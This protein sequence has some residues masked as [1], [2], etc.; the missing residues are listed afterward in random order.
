MTGLLWRWVDKR[1]A[2]SLPPLQHR[3]TLGD[4]MED[5]ARRT[6]SHGLLLAAWWLVRECRDVSRVYR[7]GQYPDSSRRFRMPS[8]QLPELRLAAR[9]LRRQPGASAASIVTLATAFAAALA[10]W[11]L[12]DSVLLTPVQATNP[13]RLLVVRERYP[14]RDG[15][16]GALS[17]HMLFS[18]LEPLRASTVLDFVA[19]IGRNPL[20]IGDPARPV[21]KDVAFVTAN[22]FDT[23]GVRIIHGRGFSTEDDKAGAPVLAV[24]TH[25]YWQTEFQADPSVLGKTIRTGNQTATIVGVAP[26]GFR[27][28]NVVD[29]P[30]LFLPAQTIYDVINRNMDYL[31]IGTPGT[32]PVSFFSVVGRLPAGRTR[33]QVAAALAALPAERR[34]V[35]EVQSLADAALP[36]ATRPNMLRFTRLLAVTVGLLLLIG[37]LT[38]GLLVLIRS[39]SRR[40]EL[41]MCLALGATKWRL[42]RGVLAESVLLSIAGLT[43]AAPLTLILLGAARTFE[44]PGRISV[45]LL[46]LTV[47][48]RVLVVGATLA[49]LSTTLIGLVAGLVGV[50]GSV[51]DVLRG[52]T[53]ATPRLSRR[54]TRQALIV[55]QV[56]VTTVLLIGTGLF[57]R[58]VTTALGL[59]AAYAPAEVLT[60]TISVRGLDYAPENTGQFFDE[61]RDR[62]AAHP[63]VASLGYRDSSGGMG[64]GG[65]VTFNGAARQV[66]SFLA[67]NHVDDRYFST[68]GL[69]ILRGRDFSPTDTS[70][71]EL[72]GIVSESLGRFM[73]NGGDPL[74]MTITESSNRIGQPAA[75]LRI[76]GV[77]PDLVTNVN[78]LEPLALYYT[79][80]QRPP[81]T[82]RVLH[83]RSRADSGV[84]TTELRRILEQIDPRITIQPPVTL[85]DTVARQMAPQRFGAAVLGALA[86]VALILTLLGTYVIAET[87]AKARERELGV[88]AALGATAGHLGGLVLKETAWLIG[89][90][91]AGGL[92]LTWLA[93]S[94]VEALLYRTEPFDI[95]AIVV[96]TLAILALALLVSVRPALRATRIDIANLLRE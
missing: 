91:L 77:V 67:Y 21:A 13:D 40:E 57:V 58:S 25:R 52:R 14:T 27:G 68:M 75:V 41:A 63:A 29:A 31:H 66:P 85:A 32:S 8:F 16:R 74:G 95:P 7:T 20:L 38:V 22:F 48:A 78:V 30:A 15:S 84:I 37:S 33:E 92:A 89:L 2:R 88:R 43:L 83:V 4:L 5:H 81:S 79:M 76:V 44:L 56:A 36:D 86:T 17:A 82:G 69:R 23:L 35:F 96:A 72:V 1:L 34:G 18:R 61:V 45:D 28:L 6:R 59:N 93:S 60:A 64:G 3:T 49:F 55:T 10:T 19:A 62:L 39:E 46:A 24:L 11:V 73:A 90:G 9:R 12:I 54:R 26:A 87:M 94:T 51:A 42:V 50:G 65:T 70:S 47:D 53:G 71:S 80:Q